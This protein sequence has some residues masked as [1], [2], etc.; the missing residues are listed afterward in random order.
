MPSADAFVAPEGKIF[1]E[2]NTAKDGTGTSYLPGDSY[3]LSGK[4]VVYAIWE[5]CYTVTIVANNQEWGSLEGTTVIGGLI[6]GTPIS[7]TDGTVS[8]K[9]H[10]CTAVPNTPTAQ[11]TYGFD[12]WEGIPGD[13]VVTKDITITACFTRTL[14][15]YT[16]TFA[17]N[18]AAWGSLAGETVLRDVPYGTKVDISGM[19]VTVGTKNCKAVPNGPT[20]QYTYGFARWDDI[21]DDHVIT[22]DATITAC[23][24]R[25]VNTYTVTFAANESG[26][27]NVGRGS[28]EN[29][30]YGT[31]IDTSGST[32]T[33]GQ[34]SCKA[35][36]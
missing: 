13:Y 3:T 4:D 21:P 12:H 15:T 30:P 19:S 6:Q 25:T 5:Q 14:N 29:I 11:Y 20:A 27:G 18:D 33:V 17:A 8:I 32:V 9:E 2:Y 35:T 34:Y 23:F 10:T 28:V 24:T 22:G 36:P 7:V 1:K 31:A 16:V 26:W